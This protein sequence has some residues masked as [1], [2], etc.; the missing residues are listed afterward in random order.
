MTVQ[1]P[2]SKVQSSGFQQAMQS[3]LRNILDCECE[4]CGGRPVLEELRPRII[5]AFERQLR[6]IEGFDSADFV[7][8][9]DPYITPQHVQALQMLARGRDPIHGEAFEKILGIDARRRKEIM[10][11][12]RDQWLLPVCATRQKPFGYFIAKT[13]DEFAA[14]METTR[15]QAISELSVAYRVFRVNFPELAGQQ[16]LKIVEAVTD[17]LKEAA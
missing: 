16:R 12:L 6:L 17:G 4:F 15:S 10:R 2:K 9:S 1:S 7:S 3:A 5:E 14:W 13:A 8:G 11:E